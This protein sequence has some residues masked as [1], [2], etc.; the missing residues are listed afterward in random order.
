MKKYLEILKIVAIYALFGSIWI[1]S[2]DIV[3]GWFIPDPKTLTELSIY[4]GIFF[5]LVTS[6]LLYS[7]IA[8]HTR[9]IQRSASDLLE[10]QGQLRSLVQTIPDLVWL[11]N[12]D[13]VFISCNQT[14]EKLLGATEG[15]ITGKTDYDFFD[16]E[17]ADSFR[18]NDRL[19]IAQ[20]KPCKNEE[21]V[22]FADDGST[23]L[24]ETIKTPMYDNNGRLIGVLGIGRDITERFLATQEQERLHEKLC[25]AN[26]MESVGL[27]AGGVAHDFNNMLGVIIG[28]AEM[29]MTKTP[30]SESIF[31]NLE[32]I[33]NAANRSANITRQLLTFAR[34]QTVVPV[35]L[36]INKTIE[37]MHG[38]LRRLI[39]ED[40]E[41]IWQPG[42]KLKMVKMDPSQLDQILVTLCVNS[43]DAI[44]G[45][46]II[47]I[48]TDRVS[49]D[50]AFC[51]THPDCLPGTF[52]LLSV[53]DNGCGIDPKIMPHLFEPFFTTKEIGKGTGLGLATVYGIVKQN[54]GFIVIESKPGKGATFN[55]YLPQDSEENDWTPKRLEKKRSSSRGHETI[56]LV[57]DEPS[58][59]EMGKTMLENQ[60]YNVIVASNP[61]EA[62]RL[63][64]DQL[65]DVQLLITDVI[66]PKMNGRVLAENISS[67]CPNLKVLFMSGYTSDIIA[68]QG[69]LD[70]SV[71][72]IHKPF[73]NE[74]FTVAVREILDLDTY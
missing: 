31:S 32:E 8:R 4:K 69:L 39:G 30:R 51:S 59:L 66:M 71:N 14:F 37:E 40:I 55:I 1:Y 50:A 16:R 46:G 57:E 13:G 44:G 45:T 3:L 10:S 56:L 61:D 22:T 26:K 41:L 2:S 63:I 12:E 33:R 21:W 38:I 15:E 19:A 43:R 74:D 11:K 9:N 47:K 29:A 58:V 17:I 20:G 18:T 34:K 67:V 35:A 60:G 27:L 72:F 73:S 70:E 36:D 5:I 28:H 25:Q 7:L 62:I 54:G 48:R 23:V 52:N 49:F 53:S 64:S 24:L 65:Y 68:A 6:L 42:E